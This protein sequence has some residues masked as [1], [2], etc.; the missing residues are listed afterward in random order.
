MPASV[1]Q[2]SQEYLDTEDSIGEFIQQ[3]LERR[4]GATVYASEVY[5]VFADWQRDAGI[6]TP[7]TQRAM[8]Q[9]LIERGYKSEK[10]AQGKRGYRNLAISEGVSKNEYR[11]LRA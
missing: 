1:R 3:H 8:S 4:P 9:A 2:A 11:Y 10:L 7:W 6:V 5:R